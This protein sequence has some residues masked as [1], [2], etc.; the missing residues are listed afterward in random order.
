[1]EQFLENIMKIKNDF[2]VIDKIDSKK[3]YYLKG[4]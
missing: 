1:M 4:E 2:I 3:Y